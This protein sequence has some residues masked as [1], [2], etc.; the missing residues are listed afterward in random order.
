MKTY[1]GYN[2]YK[3]L[4][5][6]F[7]YHLNKQFGKSLVSVALYGSVARGSAGENSDIDLLLI[8][9]KPPSNYHRRIE[10]IME[11]EHL[12]EPSNEYKKLKKRSIE[13]Y[14][15]YI[16]FSKEEASENRYIF[17]DM[18][19]DAKIL[20]DQN[21]FFAKRLK[22]IK[23]RLKKLGSIKVYLG[24]GTWYWDLKPDL[25]LGEVFSL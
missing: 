25:K 16:I 20:F 23:D 1:I 24:D 17:L 4:L 9:D 10:S 2:D 11:I 19:E 18:I 3:E 12:L 8:I 14:L 6:R 13:P 5:D 21:N 7:L 15:N 22:E